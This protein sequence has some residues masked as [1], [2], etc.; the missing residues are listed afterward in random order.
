M[1][2][3]RSY[4]TL[5]LI[6]NL[7]LLTS[8]DAQRAEEKG[9]LNDSKD[10]ITIDKIWSK[11]EFSEQRSRGFAFQK[12]GTHY[13]VVKQGK[14][15]QKNILNS[16]E[17]KIL[18]DLGALSFQGKAI[19][20]QDY[21]F[22]SDEKKI[23]FLT[24]AKR[25][26]RHS[27]SGVYYIYDLVDQSLHQLH[28]GEQIMY[29]T[30]APNNEMV[31]YVA[32]NNLFL[33]AV[34]SNN[35]I[36]VTLDGKV[37]EIINGAADWVY[38][39]EF[40]I[41][42]LYEWSPD[43]KYVAFVRFDEREVPEFTMMYYKN[44]LYPEPYTFKY[45][46]VDEKNSKVSIHTYDVDAAKLMA[47]GLP[48][49]DIYFPR[50]K[51]TNKNTL[52]VTVLNRLQNDLKL[53][54]VNPNNGELTT[55]LEEK[56]DTYLD[57]TD[58]LTFLKNQDKFIW[59]SERS[60]YNHLYLFDMKGNML[61]DMTD[62]DYDVTQYYG[63]DEANQK[64]YFQAAMQSPL[65]REVYSF[66]IK[67]KKIEKISKA[68]GW[69]NASFNDAFTYYTLTYSTA[70]S[71]PIKSINSIDGEFSDVLLTNETLERKRKT[72]DVSPVEFI[73]VPSADA[74]TNLNAY[75]IKPRHF[76]SR[77]SYPV[78]MYLYGGPGSQTVKNSYLGYNYWW[79]QMLADQ[80]YIV[81]S[82]DNRGTGGRGV[83][84]KKC[85]Y[86]QLG[87]LETED[88]I[89][90]AQYLGKLP[91]VDANRIG[92]FGWS[93]GGYM[94]SLCLFKGSDVFK[95]GIAVAPVTNWK[96]YDTIYTER[97]MRSYAEN[98]AGYDENSPIFFADQ[99]KGHYLL[100]HG[101]ADDNVHFQNTAELSRQL[102]NLGKQYDTYVYP[103]D[104]H[105]LSGKGSRAH[106]Y[107]KMTN[108]ILN[109]L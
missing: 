1:K 98:K 9:Q 89:A 104:A 73:E 16:E 68:R 108:F 80:G 106:L 82:V 101:M 84:F 102:I 48:D 20:M 87:R 99:L 43:S 78:F 13:T 66:D 30:F 94:S 56:S 85:T 26:Y 69:N 71:V 17:E 51:W 105:G 107:T 41:D 61:M 21:S 14:L 103:N 62:G 55:L 67:S 23:L 93:Y 10:K 65:E 76:D 40:T 44:Q 95:L 60:G 25:I 11:G 24:E 91:Y 34:N 54:L 7:Y 19:Y 5:I 77:K 32:Q 70:N 28:N 79:F 6:F 88:Q 3:F 52:C 109:N 31:A 37:N 97:Y 39:E 33:Q 15:V 22:S 83:D 58:D 42:R 53:I 47:T 49:G 38:E 29:P 81:V 100:V 8:V 72:Y 64:L 57:V 18:V 50:I 2:F 92:I 63:F 46:K 90:A 12:D 27:F 59:S 4:L 86:M 36:Q 45:P 96:W 74:K 75:I 35:Q